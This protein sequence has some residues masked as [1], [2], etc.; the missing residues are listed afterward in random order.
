MS[1]IW[2]INGTLYM[3]EKSA[4]KAARGYPES[5]G[6]KV[7]VYT[8]NQVYNTT[9]DFITEFERDK[10][11]RT[12]LGEL[13]TKEIKELNYNSDVE[14]LL[15]VMYK[16]NFPSYYTAF[17]SENKKKS[18]VVMNFIKENKVSFL[19]NSK[20]VEYYKALIKL[21]G[22]AKLSKREMETVYFSNSFWKSKEEL[23]V[24]PAYKGANFGYKYVEQI[25]L[26][27]TYHNAFDQAK[28]ELKAK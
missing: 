3:S 14:S 18:S 21:T 25:N 9:K 20:D 13:T 22:F 15:A 24:T 28:K 10:Q 1:K 6:V 27:E 11:L 23:E 4:L 5:H 8:V 12:I 16:I 26:D 7:E 17:I 19:S 2:L